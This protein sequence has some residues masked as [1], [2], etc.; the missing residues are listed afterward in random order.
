MFERVGIFY[1]FILFSFVC[2]KYALRF[3]PSEVS[4]SGIMYLG[5]QNSGIPEFL[6]S[7]NSGIPGRSRLEMVSE[8][9]VSYEASLNKSK[10][11]HART[12]SRPKMTTLSMKKNDLEFSSGSP[13]SPGSRGSTLNGVIARC[14]RPTFYA[15]VARMTVVLT[16]LPQINSQMATICRLC[17]GA[18]AKSQRKSF[19]W[20][21][22]QTYSMTC[23]LE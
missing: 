6:G 19:N 8:V 23:E 1:L 12:P 22:W 11:H 10:K 4:F 20:H 21:A 17:L 9:G 5:S 13:G 7:Q 18:N 14:S 15:P 16:K 3:K 2:Q